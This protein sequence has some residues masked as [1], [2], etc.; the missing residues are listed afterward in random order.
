MERCHE[1]H[2]RSHHNI[3]ETTLLIQDR[4]AKY[5][6]AL[7]REKKNILLKITLPKT[8]GDSYIDYGLKRCSGQNVNIAHEEIKNTVILLLAVK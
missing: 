7:R 3:G 4:P 8:G 5:N 1:H 2:L 6:M